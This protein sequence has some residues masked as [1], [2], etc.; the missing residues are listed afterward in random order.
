MLFVQYKLICNSIIKNINN[1]WWLWFHIKLLNIDSIPCNFLS[2]RWCRYR[3]KKVRVTAFVKVD[4][5]RI[6][7]SSLWSTAG[8]CPSISTCTIVWIL[9]LFPDYLTYEKIRIVPSEHRTFLSFIL[10]CKVH[11]SYY[12]AVNHWNI[13]FSENLMHL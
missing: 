12:F 7:S 5:D 9:C 4:C 11:L 8:I 2:E 10:L 3:I 13:L 6:N 1:Q